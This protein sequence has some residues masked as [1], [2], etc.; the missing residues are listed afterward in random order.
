MF[1]SVPPRSGWSGCFVQVVGAAKHAIACR[2]RVE[3]TA[4]EQ[5]KRTALVDPGIMNNLNACALASVD[6]LQI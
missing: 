6:S 4:P 2:E 5:G 1:L 3:Q